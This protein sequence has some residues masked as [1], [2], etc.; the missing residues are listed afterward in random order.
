MPSGYYLKLKLEKGGE[1]K[2]ES[3]VEGYKGQL[4]I[5]SFAWGVVNPG[6]L[7]KH[8]GSDTTAQDFNL[9]MTTC[10]ASPVLMQACAM[11]D[12]IKEFKLAL[13]KAVSGE[14]PTE[15]MSWTIEEAFISSYQIGGSSGVPSDS[16]SINFKTIKV[17]FK[18]QTKGG[19]PTKPFKGSYDF[20]QQKPV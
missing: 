10:T 5:D 3:E 16:F 18:E 11:G 4:E 1:V 6:R 9:T 13:V 15:Y 7:G 20:G 2:G 8:E 19:T 14:K 12:P 17:E